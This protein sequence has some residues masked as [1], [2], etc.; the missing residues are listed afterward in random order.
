[1]FL[2]LVSLAAAAD[3]LRLDPW[4]DGPLL[5]ATAGYTVAAEFFLDPPY[6]T[7]APIAEQKLALDARYAGLP[8]IDGEGPALLSDIT[9]L[10]PTYALPLVMGALGALQPPGERSRL[11]RA[12]TFAAVGLEVVTVNVTLTDVIKRAVRRPRPYACSD[13]WQAEAAAD[14]AAGEPVDVD[15]QMS[16]PSGHTS[17]AGAWTFALA[18][19]W[20]LTHD[21]PWYLEALPYLGA[22]GITVWTGALRV[23]AHKHFPTDVLVG[24][25]LG[26]GVGI[27]VPE[28]HRS[29]RVAPAV[30]SSVDGTPLLGLSGLW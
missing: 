9:A 26:A 6:L 22:S 15:A 25:L 21:G 18:H 28:S 5:G 19:T 1:M 16:F 7:H 10:Y 8:E 27:L 23:R 13:D 3:D 20:N 4:V 29:S 30:A 11:G 2:L 14:L 24:G 12:G 17:S